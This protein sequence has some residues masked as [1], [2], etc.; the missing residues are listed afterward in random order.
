MMVSICWGISNTYS[1]H[2]YRNGVDILLQKNCIM[3]C[4]IQNKDWSLSCFECAVQE[5]F[6]YYTHS[7]KSGNDSQVSA[8]QW[9]FFAY[10]ELNTFDFTFGWLWL[11]GLRFSDQTFKKN[12]RMMN[13]YKVIATAVPVFGFLCSFSV[14]T[15]EQTSVVFV[16]AACL[17]AG[18]IQCGLCIDFSLYYVCSVLHLQTV[19]ML[20]VPVTTLKQMYRSAAL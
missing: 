10:C 15:S 9:R 3:H 12:N 7:S 19:S 18:L 6:I 2:I 5:V 20:P 16:H 14:F 13:R 11:P 4:T 8:S 1:H 17:W